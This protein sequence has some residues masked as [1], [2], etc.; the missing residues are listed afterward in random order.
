M[1]VSLPTFT[2]N[3]FSQHSAGDGGGLDDDLVVIEC[4]PASPKL[5]YPTEASS[6]SAIGQKR[7]LYDIIRCHER[8]S[9]TRPS[10]IKD[11]HSLGRRRLQSHAE[12]A[13][14]YTEDK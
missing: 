1:E 3:T 11:L 8:G 12:K 4:A 2:G 13:R 14:R 5:M 6:R 10:P 7:K 9:V